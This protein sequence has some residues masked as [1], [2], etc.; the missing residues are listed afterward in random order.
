MVVSL[1]LEE[2]EPERVV[3]RLTATTPGAGG[4][5]QIDVRTVSWQ[6]DVGPDVKR[7]QIIGDAEAELD[8]GLKE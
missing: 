7:V 1:D 4:T 5:T 6:A 8:V 3:L 2:V